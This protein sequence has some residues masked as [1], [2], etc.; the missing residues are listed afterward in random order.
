MRYGHELGQ[1]WL[2][3]YGVVGSVEVSDVEV[4]VLDVVVPNR[5]ELYWEGDLSKRLGC[6]VRYHT[7]EGGIGGCE[8][9]YSKA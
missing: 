9:S 5:A 8:V 7:L 6:P 2:T 4:D 1:S 3:K